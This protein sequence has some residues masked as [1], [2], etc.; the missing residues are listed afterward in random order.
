MF[1]RPVA[2]WFRLTFLATEPLGVLSRL[3][4]QKSRRVEFLGLVS[5]TS[6][7]W[8]R[9]VLVMFVRALFDFIV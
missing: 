6:M 7:L 8:R 3:A 4:A 1:R 9:R 5:L 2:T